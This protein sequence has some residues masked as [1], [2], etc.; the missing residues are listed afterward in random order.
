MYDT[1]NSQIL[2][3]NMVRCRAG[4]YLAMNDEDGDPLLSGMIGKNDESL[5]SLPRPG[6]RP[7][8]DGPR[9]TK[10]MPLAV[11]YVQ[12]I[13]SSNRRRTMG[14]KDSYQGRLPE[15]ARR[16]PQQR[17]L[18][19][20][21]S[22][23]VKGSSRRDLLGSS[24]NHKSDN[25]N[26]RNEQE[27]KRPAFPRQAT[28]PASGFLSNRQQ[29]SSKNVKETERKRPHL[30][31]QLSLPASS[32]HQQER[33]ATT[34]QRFFDKRPSKN[35]SHGSLSSSA[36]HPSR[37]GGITKSSRMHRQRSSRR[38]NSLP[39]ISSSCASTCSLDKGNHERP[40]RRHQHSKPAQSSKHIGASTSNTGNW[41]EGLA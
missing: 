18:Q 24:T 25:N 32:L 21:Q 4:G 31:R 2:Q 12:H 15:D 38:T 37:E 30:P 20:A 34:P 11:L 23:G 16:P 19:R 14:G 40:G 26:T 10:S 1:I 17:Q 13:P 27:R 41:F 5:Y 3:I 8:A 39:V 28:T 36:H 29:K 22:S 9:R 35:A 6:G 7:T 33:P